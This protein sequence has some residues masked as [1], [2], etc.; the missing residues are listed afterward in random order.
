MAV[1]QNIRSL[2]GS[3]VSYYRTRRGM[4]QRELGAAVHLARNSISE[5]ETGT[6]EVK[7]N[8]LAAICETLDV[9]IQLMFVEPGSE[10]AVDALILQRYHKDPAFRTAVDLLMKSQES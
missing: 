8:V 9:P 3:N 4:S 2:I 10:S 7:A 5:I 6:R 1:E